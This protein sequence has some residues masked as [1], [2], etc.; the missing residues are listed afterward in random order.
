MHHEHQEHRADTQNKCAFREKQS[1]SELLP[2]ELTKMLLK[3]SVHLK[4][5]SQD[6]AYVLQRKLCK[7]ED[8]QMGLI[9][10]AVSCRIAIQ[11]RCKCN[12]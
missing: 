7:S 5:Y 11:Q 10:T 3:A 1:K 2:P 4:N 6:V 12:A 9:N 8:Q